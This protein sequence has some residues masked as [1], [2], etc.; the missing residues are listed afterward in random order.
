MQPWASAAQVTSVVVEEQDVELPV[1]AQPEG[2]VGQTHT[3]LAAVQI[4][5]P[6]DFLPQEKYA[7]WREIEFTF[8]P[9]EMLGG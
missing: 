7:Q 1:A 9:R 2:W 5:A 8:D 3:P 6:Y 4:C